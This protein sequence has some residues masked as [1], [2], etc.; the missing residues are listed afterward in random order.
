MVPARTA[1]EKKAVRMRKR[2]LALV[3][4]IILLAII[5]VVAAFARPCIIRSQM[6]ANE[7]AAIGSLRALIAAQATYISRHGVYGTLDQLL[8]DDLIGRAVIGAH[9]SPYTIIEIQT[10]TDYT[11]CFA[12][13]PVEDARTGR[14]EYCITQKGVIYEAEFDTSTVGVPLGVPRVPGKSHMPPF[15][16]TT[17]ERHPDIWKPIDE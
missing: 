15:F 7:A 10:D 11:Y 6:C 5:A 1:E 4:L 8:A 12:A 14:K 9:D 13:I 2:G 17:P 16:T 3:E